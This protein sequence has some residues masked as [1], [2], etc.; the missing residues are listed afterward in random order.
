MPRTVAHTGRHRPPGRHR[1]PHGTDRL[2]SPLHPHLTFGNGVKALALAVSALGLATASALPPQPA[3]LQLAAA[4][5]PA[6]VPV[7]SATTTG[8]SQP[9]QFGTIGFSATAASRP[10]TVRAATHRPDRQEKAS[11]GIRRTG[12]R[13]ELGL[14]QHGIVVL[15]AIR[16]SFPQIHSFGGYRAGDMDHGSGN[17][18][19]TMISSQ[20]QGDAVAAYVIAHAAELDVKYVIWRR[21]IWYPSSGSWRGMA[22]RG[23]P[24]A[25][26]MDHVHVS[27]R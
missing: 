19:D 17:A 4:T 9:P 16:D 22:D 21:R 14:T 5:T 26:H 7:R 23:S 1:K 2:H 13:P 11:R 10:A 20:A 12:L 18:V 15:N 3:A 24:T 8:P 27:V 6:P 25:N